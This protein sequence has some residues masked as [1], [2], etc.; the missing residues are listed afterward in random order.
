MNL[1]YL[2]WVTN[3]VLPACCTTDLAHTHTF[4]K[5]FSHIWTQVI[6]QHTLTT[7]TPYLLLLS[8]TTT[9]TTTTTQTNKQNNDTAGDESNSNT[10]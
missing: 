2:V 6:N 5:Q 10:G 3:Y 7:N 8:T 4:A 1:N 9:T